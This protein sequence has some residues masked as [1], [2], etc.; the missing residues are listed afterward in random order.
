MTVT[1]D[2]RKATQETGYLLSVTRT[3]LNGK[4]GQV[5]PGPRCSNLKTAREVAAWI[6]SHLPPLIGESV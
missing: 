1:V 5:Y 4:G 6:E 2:I 3:Y